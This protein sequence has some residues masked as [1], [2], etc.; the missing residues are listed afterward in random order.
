[1]CGVKVLVG[2]RVEDFG[3]REPSS[4]NRLEATPVQ[5][6]AALT[7]TTQFVQPKL[8]DLREKLVEA[9]VVSRHSMVVKPAL[10]HLAKPAACVERAKAG[11]RAKAKGESGSERFFAKSLKKP[12]ESKG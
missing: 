3:F 11:Q 4:T 5:T 8:F 7:S 6:V 9:R 1:V 10:D 12:D 2:I